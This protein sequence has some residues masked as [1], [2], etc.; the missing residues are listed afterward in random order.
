MWKEESLK[1][2]EQGSD[3][4]QTNLGRIHLAGE[5]KMSG[6]GYGVEG[7]WGQGDRSGRHRNTD[8]RSSQGWR[9]RNWQ[10]LVIGKIDKT[11]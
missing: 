7:T 10:G 2:F 11:W 6:V 8:A 4:M 1:V 3:I 5:Y 9:G